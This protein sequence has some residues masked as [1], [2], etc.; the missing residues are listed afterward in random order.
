MVCIR[1]QAAAGEAEDHRA[2]TRTQSHRLTTA[3]SHAQGIDD[4]GR[5]GRGA[6]HPVH[7]AAG[8]VIDV[9]RRSKRGHRQ[10]TAGETCKARAESHSAHALVRLIGGKAVAAGATV[11]AGHRPASDQVVRHQVGGAIHLVQENPGLRAHIHI[12]RRAAQGK[13]GTGVEADH[14]A[15]GRVTSQIGNGERVTTG[16]RVAQLVEGEVGEAAGEI[17]RAGALRV[18]G[19]AAV[20]GHLGSIKIQRHA[21]TEAVRGGGQTLVVERE[22]R[23]GHIHRAAAEDGTIVAESHPASEDVRGARVSQRRGELGDASGVRSR[24]VIRDRTR[25][26]AAKRR[27]DVAGRGVV[28]EH[29]RSRA[30]DRAPRARK[31]VAA[32]QQA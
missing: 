30:G 12:I 8:A 21:V 17:H 22:R 16:R 7:G 11:T 27:R 13:A 4:A 1:H 26:S 6:V 28:H 20:H 31:H 18:K 5:I 9:R 3:R 10:V 14:A 23:V 25:K 19:L 15:I 29:S 32:G 24:L 2:A